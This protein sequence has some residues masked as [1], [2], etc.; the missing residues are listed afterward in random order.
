MREKYVIITALRWGIPV[1]TGT[2]LA[3]NYILHWLQ[4]LG[5]PR[6]KNA[7]FS[8]HKETE[9]D[10]FANVQAVALTTEEGGGMQLSYWEP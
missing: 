2:L 1:D 9:F 4:V 3:K 5:T 10:L 6:P 7:L 8:N